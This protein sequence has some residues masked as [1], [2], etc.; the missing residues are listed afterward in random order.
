MAVLPIQPSYGYSTGLEAKEVLEIYPD[1]QYR[2]YQQSSAIH[3]TKALV[4]DELS[5]AEYDSLKAFFKARKQ[6][7]G[8]GDQFFVYDPDVVNAPDLTG[9]SATG[10]HNAI[11]L[12][13]KVEFVRDGP[14]SYSGTL[15]VLFLD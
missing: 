2:R 6:A 12:D 1:L 5:Q 8:I 15:T 9:A 14:C 7:T 10:R 13:S 3:E 11:F 4:F